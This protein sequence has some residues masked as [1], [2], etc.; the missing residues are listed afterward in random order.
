MELRFIE[1]HE[2]VDENPNQADEETRKLHVLYRNVAHLIQL[3]E[4]SK[5]PRILIDGDIEIAWP[6]EIKDQIDARIV[7]RMAEIAGQVSDLQNGK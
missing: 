6:Q 7:T 3:N 2:M 5:A 1:R 4:A